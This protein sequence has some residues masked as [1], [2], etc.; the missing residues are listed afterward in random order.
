[1]LEVRRILLGG[2]IWIY[3][4]VHVCACVHVLMCMRVLC[5]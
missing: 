1:M 4:C 2:V 3:L 5:K